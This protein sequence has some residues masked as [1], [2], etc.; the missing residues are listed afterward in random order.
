LAPWLLASLLSSYITLR[1]SA[2]VMIASNEPDLGMVA[3]SYDRAAQEAPLAYGVSRTLVYLAA[4]PVA[5]VFAAISF[6]LVSVVT[7]PQKLLAHE[8]MLRDIR[9]YN[10]RSAKCSIERDRHQI[11]EHVAELFD[12]LED[13]ILAVAVDATDDCVEVVEGTDEIAESTS[14]RSALRSVTSY[15]DHDQCLDEFNDY[16]RYSL[17]DML[18]ADLGVETQLSFSHCFLLSLPNVLSNIVQIWA[19]WQLHKK[20]GYVSGELFFAACYVDTIFST[21][22]FSCFPPCL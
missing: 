5:A 19:S 17:R 9:S 18:V 14:S 20:L 4:S 10:I 6:L 22:I 13:P 12:G 11:E 1:L 8:T 7:F 2:F 3:L 16:V 21:F 15:L